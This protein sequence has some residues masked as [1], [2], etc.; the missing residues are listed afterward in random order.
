MRLIDK[1]ITSQ[2]DSNVVEDVYCLLP[3]MLRDGAGPTRDEQ[4]QAIEYL[5]K[6]G[7][8]VFETATLHLSVK[9]Y[10]PHFA[11]AFSAAVVRT[12]DGTLTTIGEPVLPGH[13]RVFCRSPI[14]QADIAY[15]DGLQFG[16]PN[17]DEDVV[18]TAFF[19]DGVPTHNFGDDFGMGMR[20]PDL[21][22]LSDVR[23]LLGA[24]DV[25]QWQVEG[26]PLV[27]EGV[28]VYMAD[29]GLDYSHPFFVE[30]DPP[31]EITWYKTM[32]P[33][34]PDEGTDPVGH[35]TMCASGV[36]LM[37]P[38]THLHFIPNSMNQN[39]SGL[40]N[41]ETAIMLAIENKPSVVSISYGY[42][43]VLT[44]PPGGCPIPYGPLS[45]T[46]FDYVQDLL[47]LANQNGVVVCAAAGNEKRGP[48]TMTAWE[49]GKIKII[50]ESY[51]AIYVAPPGC[52]SR[53]LSVG[54][55]F[56]TLLH[57]PLSRSSWMASTYANSGEYDKDSVDFWQL[58]VD[59][60]IRLPDVC[61][62]VNMACTADP[63]VSWKATG[64]C[65]PW[66]TESKSGLHIPGTAKCIGKE[67]GTFP[68]P[69][70]EDILHGYRVGG[71]TSFAT[72]C[73]AGIVALLLQAFPQF[74]HWPPYWGGG[75][76]DDVLAFLRQC[77]VDVPKGRCYPGNKAYVGDDVATGSG[78]LNAT[79]VLGKALWYDLL[80]KVSGVDVEIPVDQE[81][82]PE[83]GP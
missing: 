1:S 41:L 50:G 34:V 69:G 36:F 55:A 23:R 6:H 12:A 18:E 11:S 38:K 57:A 33:G 82:P 26:R 16:W 60:I 74:P 72:P 8:R 62:I 76:F 80:A 40:A 24:A 17:P 49:G 45:P 43:G 56:P 51:D 63:Y 48:C 70:T 68:I 54:G 25:H 28:N 59:I 32:W 20:K 21:L 15:F 66:G 83:P 46:I 52:Q 61:G 53:A 44:A 73:V 30:A 14:F 58:S 2:A 29:T 35:G 81:W 31:C 65:V 47:H 4:Q 71:G 67:Q 39:L 42:P 78:V 37:A 27:G 64:I 9:G 75:T 79:L 10:A 22:F 19:L 7:L 13:L 5:E 77:C 3:F